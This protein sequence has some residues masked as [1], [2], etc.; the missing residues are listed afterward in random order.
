[1]KPRTH[2]TRFNCR[3]GAPT[4][5]NP[6]AVTCARCLRRLASLARVP[7]PIAYRDGIPVFEC[8]ASGCHRYPIR[9]DGTRPPDGCDLSFTCPRCG[10]RL[11]HGG[12]H[13]RPGAADGHRA[14]H[15]ACWPRGYYLRE[16][17]ASATGAQ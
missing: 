9:R 7:G 6:S 2:Y 11:A 3:H 5:M 8:Q 1:M 13:G 16:R 10:A 15:C 14:A 4:T 12:A 17:R